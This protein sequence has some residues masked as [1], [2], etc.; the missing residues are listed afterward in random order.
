MPSGWSRRQKPSSLPWA[1]VA[2]IFWSLVKLPGL[3][4]TKLAESN[5]LSPKQK[6]CQWLESRSEPAIGILLLMAK[7]SIVVHTGQCMPHVIYSTS[8]ALRIPLRTHLSPRR[9]ETVESS[10][11]WR[12]FM[13]EFTQKCIFAILCK[14]HRK[15]SAASG[16]R[17]HVVRK[18]WKCYRSRHYRQKAMPWMVTLITV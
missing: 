10:N 9:N 2:G 15:P 8:I 12:R 16:S 3:Q 17:L 4:H 13:S 7:M 5:A 6:S 14:L 1:M 11:R 18:F